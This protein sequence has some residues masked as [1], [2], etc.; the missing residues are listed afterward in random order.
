MYP[1]P[2]RPSSGR[3]RRWMRGLKPSTPMPHYTQTVSVPL[4]RTGQAL[5]SAGSAAT[6]TMGPSGIGGKWYPNLATITTTTGPAD[7][8]TAVLYYGFVSQST[9]I[10]PQL[11]GGGSLEGLAIPMMTPGDVVICQWTGAHPGD[12]AQL[13][14]TGSQDALSR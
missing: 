13:T 5:V 2:A 9:V 12:V 1:I 6:V 4:N 3:P 8:S 7:G 10:S 14:I 11:A